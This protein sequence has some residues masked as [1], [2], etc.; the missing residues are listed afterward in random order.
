MWKNKIT[1]DFIK[2]HEARL[3]AYYL[4]STDGDGK[5]ED[6]ITKLEINTDSGYVSY[7]IYY[8]DGTSTP[9]I[10]DDGTIINQ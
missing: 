2:H 5:S 8:K 6:D 3:K 4:M 9:T 10:F 7:K 1:L